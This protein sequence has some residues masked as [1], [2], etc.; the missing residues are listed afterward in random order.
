MKKYSLG[1]FINK[2]DAVKVYQEKRKELY[3]DYAY[4]QTEET[5]LALTPILR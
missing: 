3:G 2:T 4:D 5:L 1:R